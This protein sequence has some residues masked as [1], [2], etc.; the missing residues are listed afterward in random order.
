MNIELQAKNLFANADKLYEDGFIADVYHIAKEYAKQ[1]SNYKFP[2]PSVDEAGAISV[3]IA[4]KIRPELTPQEQVFFVAGFQ[5]CVKYLSGHS[6][7]KIK[8]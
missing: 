4:E 7:F 3:K 1:Q 6:T 2:L 8:K 5:E